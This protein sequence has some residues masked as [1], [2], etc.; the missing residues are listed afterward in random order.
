[1]FNPGVN[2]P[3]PW[4][5][6]VKRPD[7]VG[8]PIMEVRRKYMQEQI[9]FENYI[10][11][12]NTVSTV[13]TAAAGAAGGPAPSTGGGADEWDII[14]KIDT[15]IQ[16]APE[17]WWTGS[18]FTQTQETVHMNL[19]PYNSTNIR[20]QITFDL[21]PT[22]IDWGDGV[23]EEG[24]TRYNTWTEGF[25]GVQDGL[26]GSQL[27]IGGTVY[28]Y[29][30]ATQKHT[31]STPGE[32]V[33]KLKGEGYSLYNNISLAWLPITEIIKFD[34]TQITDAYGLF[35]QAQAN[36]AT[37]EQIA[38]WNTS[39]WTRIK[40]TFRNFGSNINSGVVVGPEAPYFTSSW[41]PNVSSW[42]LSGIDP[43]VTDESRRI[44]VF[45]ENFNRDLRNW[46]VSGFDYP[47]GIF[48]GCTN[49]ISG[50]RADL[51]DFSN[52]PFYG[53]GSLSFMFEGAMTSPEARGTMPHVGNWDLSSISDGTT[54][55][56]TS[57][58]SGSGFSH[59]AVG[60]TLIGWASQSLAPNN[61]SLGSNTFAS[62]WDGSGFSNPV[63]DTGTSFGAEVSA[64]FDYL[65][66]TKG[67]TINDISFI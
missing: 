65:V 1:M 40:E 37:A 25:G 54:N 11:T 51:W 12:L 5:W 44:F 9:L 27:N 53:G 49:L 67:W 58:F 35:F 52:T 13:S 48:Q 29:P 64:S 39:Q 63:F 34:P 14:L 2:D 50:A 18:A 6:Y 59:T 56:A 10:S 19:T 46:D 20:T 47:N 57:M 43:N 38:S 24:I 36:S 45:F 33:I 4:Q 3:G 41:N 32:Y 55:L 42:D 28:T 15:R 16:A 21:S 61:I 7:N 8:L 22:T 66:T 26:V 31:Y 62:T 60:E 30:H 17:Y 23:I